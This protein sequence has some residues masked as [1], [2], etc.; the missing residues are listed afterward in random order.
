MIQQKGTAPTPKRSIWK[1][2]WFWALSIIG[3]FILI[4]MLATGEDKNNI[5]TSQVKENSETQQVYL[6]NEDMQTGKARWKLLNSEN[7]GDTLRASESR[8]SS[9]ATSKTTQGKFIEIEMEVENTGEVTESF[10]SAPV[11]VD[12]RNREFKPRND[13]SEWIP[14]E[15]D[16]SLFVELQPG[17]PA[18]LVWLYEVPANATGLKAKV[19][20]ISFGGSLSALVN[21]G[22]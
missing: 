3:F 21:L 2:W 7:K 20:D 8:Y 16:A 13:L 1:K 4:G 5:N 9:I 22:L 17:I 12:D 18:Q 15:K 10:W 11:L 6:V 14:E 19:K